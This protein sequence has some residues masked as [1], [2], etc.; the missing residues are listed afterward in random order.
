MQQMLS[1][2]VLEKD[3]VLRRQQGGSSPAVH[4]DWRHGLPAL[5]GNQVV[6][7]ELR[8][9]DAPS[10]LAMLS[11]EEVARFMSPVPSTVEGYEQF[12][13]WT[14]RQ[15]AEGASLCFAVTLKGFDTAVGL[16]QVRQLDPSFATAEWG[17]AIG[18]P[19][20]GTGVF[21]DAAALVLDFVFGTI[22]AYRLEARAVAKN[23][24][25]NGAL[26]K[27]GAVREGYL[28][29][30][31][32]RDGQYFDQVLYAILADDWRA[33]KKAAAPTIAPSHVH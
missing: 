4:G 2:P 3:V 28:R 9:S 16:F 12:I 32:L 5:T 30:S 18:S 22:G 17:F 14:R 7:R 19:F 20:W 13:A 29:Q 11:A 15:R 23:G 33:A 27:M 25:G 1:E 21:A 6:L 10:L 31:L 8:V 24:R 26:L